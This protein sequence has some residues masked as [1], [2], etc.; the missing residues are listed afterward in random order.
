VVLRPDRGDHHAVL[1]AVLER[2]GRLDEAARSWMA[3]GRIH[4]HYVADAVR[5][6]GVALLA[7]G[8][9]EAAVRELRTAR[10][11]Q[12]MLPVTPDLVRA[13][14]GLAI[15]QARSGHL[16]EAARALEEALGLMP[17][18]PEVR[19]NLLAVREALRR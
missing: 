4:P 10:S 13:L 12:P 15:E 18:S 2:E 5:A 16:A 14:N 7:H 6:L 1:A 19:D 17:E 3:A 9:F 11:L 8:H